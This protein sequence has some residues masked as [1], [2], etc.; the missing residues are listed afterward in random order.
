MKASN[1]LKEAIESLDYDD[2]R[3]IR[4]ILNEMSPYRK[5]TSLTVGASWLKVSKERIKEVLDKMIQAG[6][7]EEKQDERVKPGPQ[8]KR[9]ALTNDGKKLYSALF[10]E[11]I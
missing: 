1:N 4:A 5:L 11:K 10:N 3:I 2:Q 9:Y 8:P 7:I 6:A